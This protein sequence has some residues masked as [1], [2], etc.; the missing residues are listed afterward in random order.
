MLED[1]FSP[2]NLPD[3]DAKTFPIASIIFAL[4]VICGVVLSSI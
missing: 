3:K 2:Q 1:E 4:F